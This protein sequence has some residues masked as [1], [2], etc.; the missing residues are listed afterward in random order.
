MLV[1]VKVG[2]GLRFFNVFYVLFEVY[3]H[4]FLRF[5]DLLHTFSR[6]LGV[7]VR[8]LVGCSPLTRTN[9]LFFGQKLNFLSRSQQRKNGKNIFWYVMNEKT[10]FN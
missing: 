2:I 1:T 5:F 8:G 9:P 6:T 10:E 7:R 3:R 4:D